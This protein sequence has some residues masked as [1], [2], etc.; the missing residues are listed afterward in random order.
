MSKKIEKINTITSDVRSLLSEH[1]IEDK[2]S[3]LGDISS[4]LCAFDTD[5]AIEVLKEF[6][7]EGE[8]HAHAIKV[9]YG[10]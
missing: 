7:E 10:Y 6:G 9:N 4:I 3:F 1:N 5:I 2:G 8:Y